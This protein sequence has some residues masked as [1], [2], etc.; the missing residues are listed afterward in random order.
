[1]AGRSFERAASADHSRVLKPSRSRA[2][3]LCQNR[4]IASENTIASQNT[5]L[6]RLNRTRHSVEAA[7]RHIHRLDTRQHGCRTLPRT[8]FR[9]FYICFCLEIPYGVIAQCQ[10]LV[11]P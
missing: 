11:R 4:L 1:V 6:L 7:V 3:G 2:I 8:L 5:A 10:T 9:V